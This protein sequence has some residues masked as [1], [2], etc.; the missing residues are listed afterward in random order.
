M[1]VF[2]KMIT[3]ANWKIYKKTCSEVREFVRTLKNN[4][5]KFQTDLMDAYILPDPV[6]L[7]TLIDEIG[8]YPLR[9]GTQDIF[10]EDS[11]SYTGE[12]SPLVLKDL[13]CQYVFIGHSERK[14]YF[15]ETEITINKKIHACYRNN[16]YPILLI[17]ESAEERQKNITPDV[18]RAQL[19]TGLDGIPPEF[20]PDMALVY[21]PVW[22]IGQ[23]DS[24]S[25]EIIEESH[26]IVRELLSSLYN[27]DI[28]ES[29][30]ILYGGSVN[31]KNG[32]EIIKIPDVDGLGITRG[33]LDADN[34]AD[35]I[36]MTET[37]AKK[38][39]EKRITFDT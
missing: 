11:G 3:G 17:G 28:S 38:R 36:R 37:E 30:R 14:K 6:C 35:F 34:F 24:A 39:Y 15:G 7:Q 16:I 31:I 21:E 9:Y 27:P 5:N 2:R 18:L 33:A 12:I 10:W 1:K 20:L 8:D 19:R 25:I 29:T 22:A 13:G 26:L 32:A 4:I 23:K